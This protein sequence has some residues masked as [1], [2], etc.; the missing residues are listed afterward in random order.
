MLSEAELAEITAAYRKR[1]E[2][3]VSGELG[4][5]VDTA[6]QTGLHEA[7]QL[8][9]KKSYCLQ[10]RV[11]DSERIVGAFNMPSDAEEWACEN[12]DARIFPWKIVPFAFHS[13]SKKP[14]EKGGG[15]GLETAWNAHPDRDK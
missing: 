1:F 11:G 2:G 14:S 15:T 7:L 5:L 12:V 3:R 6:F 4:K 10:I 8:L 9:A 13:D